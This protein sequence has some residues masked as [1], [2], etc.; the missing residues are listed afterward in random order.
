MDGMGSTRGVG[1]VG[2]GWEATPVAEAACGPAVAA[3]ASFCDQ[4][5]SVR[6]D[7]YPQHRARQVEL[8][9]KQ[10][11]TKP[12]KIFPA[13]PKSLCLHIAC[14]SP[15]LPTHTSVPASPAYAPTPASSPLTTVSEAS[16]FTLRHAEASA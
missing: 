12:P 6:E 1:V 2:D 10:F 5:N 7:L 15:P 8:P 16:C 13:S 9:P 14:A 3:R 4:N 11:R